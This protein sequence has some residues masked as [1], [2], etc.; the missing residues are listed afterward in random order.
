MED[1]T[2]WAQENLKKPR[3][4]E[5]ANELCSLLSL[6]SKQ[7]AGKQ[8]RADQIRVLG[9]RAIPPEDSL[10]EAR[11]VLLAKHWALLDLKTAN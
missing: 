3:R 1:R 11:K 9:F 10:I 2:I 5:W 6:I 7:G 8:E 4:D